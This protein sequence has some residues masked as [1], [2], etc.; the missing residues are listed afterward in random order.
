MKVGWRSHTCAR[1]R[2]TGEASP[3][4][5]ARKRMYSSQ[6]IGSNASRAAQLALAGL[7][8]D[9]AQA[10]LPEP[11]QENL[12]GVLPCALLRG[13]GQFLRLSHA[14]AQHAEPA[15]PRFRG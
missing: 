2:P 4:T 12:T 6:C 7:R 8:P 15:M 11:Y 1:Y 10:P 5:I 3:T 9:S 13:R 14:H